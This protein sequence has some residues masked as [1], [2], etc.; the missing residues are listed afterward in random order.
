MASLQYHKALH[1][2]GKEEANSH[3]VFQQDV[4]LLIDFVNKL[5]I[6]WSYNTASFANYLH[7]I[8]HFVM[9]SSKNIK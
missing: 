5:F 2:S 8:T 4:T 1:K 3:Q 9:I 7:K 6:F